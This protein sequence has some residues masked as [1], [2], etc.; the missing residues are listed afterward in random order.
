M[1]VYRVSGFE[2]LG[3]RVSLA[4]DSHSG[5]TSLRRESSSPEGSSYYSIMI[6]ILLLI[7]GGG[8]GSSSFAVHLNRHD[9]KLRAP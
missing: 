4:P 3:F 5:G 7:S 8:G 9:P 1:G 6:R 2:G